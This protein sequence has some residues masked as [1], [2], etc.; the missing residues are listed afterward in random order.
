MKPFTIE[1][2]NRLPWSNEL[3]DYVMAIRLLLGTYERRPEASCF[4][5]KKH[6]LES[7]Y[8]AASVD[9]TK[10]TS[11]LRSAFDIREFGASREATN[12]VLSNFQMMLI[13]PGSIAAGIWMIKGLNTILINARDTFMQQSI[14]SR[15]EFIRYYRNKYL[16]D[17]LGGAWKPRFG[18]HL[19]SPKLVA[20]AFV[21]TKTLISYPVVPLLNYQRELT[22][23]C[24][25]SGLK[26]WWAPEFLLANDR[27]RLLEPI[28]KE[29]L[30]EPTPDG[31][32]GTMF[33]RTIQDILIPSEG[34]VLSDRTL[35]E[36][37]LIAMT[38][39]ETTRDLGPNHS[40]TVNEQKKKWGYRPNRTWRQRDFDMLFDRLYLK[41]SVEDISTRYGVRKQS[42]CDPATVKRSTEYLGKLLGLKLPRAPYK[43]HQSH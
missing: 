5:A 11:R 20:K 6:K 39:K 22:K 33:P 12:K 36:W 9:I 1:D 34:G 29:E 18:W 27:A 35:N 32:L 38:G 16:R 43:K 42:E 19:F 2:A 14:R 4:W 10:W 37:S 40:R 13:V 17:S 30:A 21:A 31:L 8:L 26:C 7:E 3:L 28:P 24:F 25:T 15:S 41:L 23:L